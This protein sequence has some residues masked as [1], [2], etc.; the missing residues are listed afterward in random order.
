MI[1]TRMSSNILASRIATDLVQKQNEL[2]RVQEQISTGRRINTPSDDPAQ[3][4][5]IVKM[6]EAESQ[7][8]Q[9][10]RN[11]S[12]A[13]SQLSLEEAALTGTANTL[14]RIRELALT[15]NSGAVDD[16]TRAAHNAEVKL[17]LDE[18]YD[19]A[20]A[21]D[22][23]GNYLFSG[24]NTQTQPFTRD[25]E[26][27][28]NGSD[29]AQLTSIGLGRK[30]QTGDS[31]ADAFMR[32][33]NGN[34]TF[35]VEM[36]AANTGTGTIAQGSVLNRSEYENKP[37][38]I[39]FSTPGT[40]DI[41]DTSTGTTLQ[42]GAYESGG[43]IEFNG[44]TTSISGNP[45]TGDVFHVAP[46]SNQDIFTTVSNFVDML[47]SSPSSEAERARM[48][49]DIDVLIGNLDLSL[50]HINTVRAQVGTRLNNI[51]SSREENADI[52][53]QIERTRA[54]V[55]DIDIAEAITSLQTQMTSLQVLQQTYGK[56]ESLSL[57]NYIG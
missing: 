20:N 45:Q 34:G 57:F 17:R 21:Q 26:V 10:Q 46:S 36:D 9:Y 47:D 52:T 29:D 15:A 38:D 24:S 12:I 2:A 50:D 22:T 13:E 40:Y 49:Q 54:E 4:A 6:Q 48:Q 8:S 19:M 3:S 31:G 1:S 30:I 44:I 37:F 51:D 5:H 7:L 41:I 56:V 14:L 16:T 28:Y 42:S 35:Q 33:R 18:L 43:S 23:L 27:R 11:A 32:I 55:E 53:L 39:T 25:P